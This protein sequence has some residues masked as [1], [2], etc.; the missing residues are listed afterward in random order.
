MYACLNE[1]KNLQWLKV[2]RSFNY[3]FHSNFDEDKL[4]TLLI[5]AEGIA[6]KDL[7]RF[8]LSSLVDPKSAR[9]LWKM[10]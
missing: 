6:L 3:N 7:A 8:C 2:I 5:N 1:T 10:S 4:K 9:R